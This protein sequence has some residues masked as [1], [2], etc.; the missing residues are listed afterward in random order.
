M[1]I[2]DDLK[3]TTEILWKGALFF[4]IVDVVFVIILI[5]LI[6][7]DEFRR[8]KKNLLVIMFFFFLILFGTIMSI[9]FWD[10]VYSYVFPEWA[11]WIIPPV[12]GLLF[13]LA[14]LFFRWLSFKLPGN[15]V[16][17]FIISGGLWG[18]I[19]HFLAIQR[20]LLDKVPMLQGSSPIAACGI[21]TF[22]FIFYWCICL[23]LTKIITHK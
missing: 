12:Y 21:A 14:G 11:R 20:G 19:T 13:A 1:I 4:S 18:I 5:K 6:K 23:V 2:S 7:V 22:E 17:Y 15:A 10:S 3:V 8:M 16:I 9:V